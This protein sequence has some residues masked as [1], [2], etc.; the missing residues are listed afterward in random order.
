MYILIAS[1]VFNG[2]GHSRTVIGLE[3]S[4]TDNNK[5]FLLLLDPLK[6]KRDILKIKTTSCGN[7]VHR[8]IRRSVRQETHWQYEL[9]FING[10]ISDSKEKDV[11][12]YVCTV[13]L[14][15]ATY[16]IVKTWVVRKLCQVETNSPNFL[17][18]FTILDLN[19]ATY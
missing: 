12:I 14:Y 10:L 6:E 5:M 3:Q 7:A 17:P 13:L 19:V 18:I 15:I 8:Y 1:I 4:Q 16:C 11:S 9:V 2:I